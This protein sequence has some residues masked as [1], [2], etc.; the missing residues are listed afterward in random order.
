MAHNNG[1]NMTGK[2]LALL[3]A[4]ILWVYVMNEQNPPV[5]QTVNVKLEVRNV[6]QGLILAQSTEYVKIRYRGPRSIIAGLHQQDLEVYVDARGLEEGQHVL[7]VKTGIPG[8]LEVIEVVPN[9]VEIRLESQITRTL[10]VVPKFTGSTPPGI[11]INKIEVV[12]AQVRITGPR[13]KVETVSAVVLPVD[14][15]GVGKNTVLE[16][17]PHPC[18]NTGGIVDG[19]DVSPE[20]V[21]LQ[22][23][24]LQDSVTKTVDIKPSVIGEPAPGAAITK[25][26]TEPD[27]VEISG[28]AETLKKI[29]AVYTAPVDVSGQAADVVR[30]VKIQGPEGVTTPRGDTVK[31]S[32]HI[33]AGPSPS[34]GRHNP[35]TE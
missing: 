13:S 35:T 4:V 21:K 9:T 32:I 23:G 31:V 26:S 8:G 34:S 20:K 22:V 33:A 6:A 25:V 19:V 18:N 3:L 17:V 24:V 11:V 15:S 5:E 14:M 12:P 10:A 28:P 7:P 30:E 1:E 2:I 27:K 16:G 29:E